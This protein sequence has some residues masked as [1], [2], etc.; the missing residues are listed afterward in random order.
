MLFYAITFLLLGFSNAMFLDCVYREEFWSGNRNVYICDVK[1]VIRYNAEDRIVTGV[2]MNHLSGKGNNDVTAIRFQNQQLDFIPQSINS[3]FNNIIGLRI[4]ST[5][6]KTITKFDLQ[7]FPGLIYLYTYD[8]KFEA[9][10]GDLF[11]FTPKVEDVRFGGSQITNVG[12]NLVHHLKNLRFLDFD[13]NVCISQWAGTPNGINEIV[14][15]L[16][17][18][19]PPTAAMIE[20]SV[21]N[22]DKLDERMDEKIAVKVKAVMEM[23]RGD[24]DGAQDRTRRL[25]SKVAELE[26]LINMYI[27]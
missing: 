1:V 15:S 11:T 3:Y 10:E 6:L 16:G 27:W 7:Q 8:N 18:L 21:I 4:E 2:S 9:I 24:F 23:L 26:K 20:R 17:Q 14:R 19:C 13:R 12:T 5:T 25:E 22:G